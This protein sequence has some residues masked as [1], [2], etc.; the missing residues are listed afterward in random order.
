MIS[1]RSHPFG[2]L[3]IYAKPSV[4]HIFRYQKRTFFDILLTSLL[5]NR[6]FS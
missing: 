6:D 5:H 1:V 2:T 4:L 3:R